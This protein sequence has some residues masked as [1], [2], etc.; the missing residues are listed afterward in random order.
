MWGAREERQLLAPEMGNPH[1]PPRPRRKRQQGP[2]PYLVSSV[3]STSVGAV[4]GAFEWPAVGSSVF[5]SPLV[6]LI[7]WGEASVSAGGHGPVLTLVPPP[8]SSPGRWHGRPLTSPGRDPRPDSGAQPRRSALP[9]SPITR[10]GSVPLALLGGS[11]LLG[12]PATTP[13]E[14]GLLA[15]SPTVP[16]RH[17]PSK[18]SAPRRPC[19]GRAAGHGSCSP[20]PSPSTSGTRP[21]A[22]PRGLLPAWRCPWAPAHSP[23]QR[24]HVRCHGW[25]ET[26]ATKARTGSAEATGTCLNLPPLLCPLPPGKAGSCQGCAGQGNAKPLVP[27]PRVTEEL[28]SN[29]HSAQPARLHQA[30][31]PRK[32]PGDPGASP[33]PPCSAGRRRG[34]REGVRS[35][36]REQPPRQGGDAVREERG[37]ARACPTLC[38]GPATAV[39]GAR[40]K[41]GTEQQQ[42][43]TAEQRGRSSSG[44]TAAEPEAAAQAQPGTRTQGCPAGPRAAEGRRLPGRQRDASR[45]AGTLARVAA[46][47]RK[48]FQLLAES[49][50]LR[51]ASSFQGQV[52]RRKTRAY[53]Y[54]NSSLP[55][56]A[57]P[58]KA[59]PK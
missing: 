34:P 3:T 7:T 35:G 4:M 45:E 37:R 50:G 6:E 47:K 29:S 18:L 30:T 28:P 33:R 32:E 58:V 31:A 57:N 36:S 5:S 15:A 16:G 42:R 27:V 24:G 26:Q 49:L 21:S 40:P 1:P 52:G 38:P 14:R 17:V 11:R 59:K 43:F 25:E 54:R 55:A 46:C 12:T 51:G 9:S 56:A 48:A 41:P 39:P 2:R 10:R 8:H 19:H 22:R 13:R 53:F 23:G 20:A 44:G